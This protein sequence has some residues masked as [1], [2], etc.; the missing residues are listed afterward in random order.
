MGREGEGRPGALG[1]VAVV[2]MCCPSARR[3]PLART[4]KDLDFA[5][6]SKHRSA[7]IEL[8]EQAG[9]QPDAEFT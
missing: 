5:S 1:G 2:Q 4:P 3:P 9:Y 6:I 8:F 7:I